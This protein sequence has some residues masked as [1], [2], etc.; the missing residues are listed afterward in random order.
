[1]ATVKE[2]NSESD[3]EE[4]K[5]EGGLVIRTDGTKSVIIN[6]AEALRKLKVTVDLERFLKLSLQEQRLMV[7]D[8]RVRIKGEGVQDL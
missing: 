8:E 7:I 1:M 3:E 6:Q 4:F 5:D 2:E